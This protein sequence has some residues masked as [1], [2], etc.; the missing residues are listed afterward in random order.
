MKVAYVVPRYGVEVVG[1]AELAARLLAEHLVAAGCEV[2]AFTTCALD[3]RTWADEYPEG[4]AEVNG[5]TVHRF[6]S[7]AGRDPA[8]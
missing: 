8:F 3:A 2:E 4:R 5:V 1:G 6:R 7:A